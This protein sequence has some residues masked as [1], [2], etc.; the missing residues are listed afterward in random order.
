MSKR[1]KENDTMLNRLVPIV[2][3]KTGVRQDD[4]RMMIRSIFE[5]ITEEMGRGH[6]VIITG[7][8]AF[9]LLPTPERDYHSP[10]GGMHT[11]PPHYRIHFKPGKNLKSAVSAVEVD[12]KELEM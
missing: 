1:N 10:V 12:P 2:A 7:F 11:V 3:D 9:E 4:V 5:A 8:G 6:S